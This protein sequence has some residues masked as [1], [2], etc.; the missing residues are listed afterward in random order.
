MIRG[1]FLLVD[2]KRRAGQWTPHG[3]PDWAAHALTGVPLFTGI[4]RRH[5]RKI[6]GLISV[7][8]YGDGVRA[9]RAGS[10]GEAFHIVLDGKALVELP[11]GDE[12]VLKPGDAFGDLALID[13]APRSATVIAEARAYIR[14]HRAR[15][16]PPSVRDEL[17]AAMAVGL[18][19]GLVCR[20]AIANWR[21]PASF[22]AFERTSTNSM[23]ETARQL[24]VPTA[25]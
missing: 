16:L 10:K 3:T 13:G 6:V 8:E 22:E 18:L 1:D 9:V 5:L 12:I 17:T 19:P 23:R 2:D 4:S 21:R 25:V 24:D 11:G 14:A 7:R 15:R 20:G